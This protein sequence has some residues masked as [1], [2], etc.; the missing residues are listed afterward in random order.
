MRGTMRAN[1]RGMRLRYRYPRVLVLSLVLG[2]G[3]R[4]IAPGPYAVGPGG[5]SVVPSRRVSAKG[6]R[7]ELQVALPEG[8]SCEWTR[9]ALL[10]RR[11]D[12]KLVTVSAAVVSTD[13]ARIALPWR[14]TGG[15]SRPAL[16][17]EANLPIDEHR[18][19]VRVELTASDSIR[20]AT[21]SWWSGKPQ[22][23]VP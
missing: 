14:G 19:I 4:E 10:V 6:P 3:P 21:L 8:Y 15:S 23:L 12:G 1:R 2:C 9:D 13:R 20:V 11:P 5:T 22:A 17:F 7:L 18:E 16:I